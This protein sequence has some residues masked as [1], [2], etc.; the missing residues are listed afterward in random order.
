[1]TRSIKQ[2]AG[3]F[4]VESTVLGVLGGVVGL[5]F[6]YGGLR[7]LLAMAPTNIPR[8]EEIT[9]GPEVFL[10]AL[11][12]SILARLFFGLFPVVRYGRFHLVT[13]LKEGGRG[14]SSGRERHRV[15]NT[16]VVAQMALALIL[17]I[18]SG[19]MIR[20]AQALR[21]VDPGFR[22]PEEILS[23]RL[24][25]PPA[26]VEDGEQAA[27]THELIAS[28]IE[29]IPGVTSVGL[30]SSITMDGWDSNDP[31]YVEDFPAA[32]G[33]LPP[34]R[35]F[36]YVGEGYFETMQNSIV[37][38]RPITMADIHDHGLVVMITENLAREYWDT[39]GDA[40][41]KRVSTGLAPGEAGWREIVG[42]A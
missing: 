20:S 3:Q 14:S 8:F 21:S 15:R 27:L 37:A 9:L 10:F 12:I 18:G 32:D 39:P 13:A 29:E 41:G 28:R 2:V 40:L 16:L 34:I 17:L 36:K 7:I 33:Q 42:V 4:L 1:M 5:A 23:L 6:A 31:I 35:R 30:T 25:I 19:L 26:E 38:G 22:S 24:Y 11:V